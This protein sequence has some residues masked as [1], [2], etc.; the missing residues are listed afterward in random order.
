M[1]S[2]CYQQHANM[3]SSPQLCVVAELWQIATKLTTHHG[4]T[5][6]KRP[7]THHGEDCSCLFLPNSNGCSC[8]LH[9]FG[10]GNILVVNQ[11]YMGVGLHLHLRSFV[12]HKLACYTMNSN[13]SDGC[14]VCFKVREYA[15]GNND[16]RLDGAIVR[17][18]YVFTAN[19]ENCSMCRLFH[20]N[21]GYAYA[22]VLSYGS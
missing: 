19:H 16:H 22:V 4:T 10:C 8:E 7:Q 20:H 12:R 15:A 11:D 5:H 17:I 21:H 18:T 2:P 13:G 6:I 3:C 9:P 14:C 1:D